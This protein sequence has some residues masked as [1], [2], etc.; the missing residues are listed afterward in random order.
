MS[1][2]KM[3][4]EE[5]S[6][7]GGINTK[8]SVYVTGEREVLDLVNFD[9]STPGAWTKRLGMTNAISGNTVTFG[10]SNRANFGF[11]V[12]NLPVANYVAFGTPAT[13]TYINWVVGCSGVYTIDIN[14]GSFR[15]F[16][17]ADGST[18]PLVSTD[19][20]GN[21]TQVTADAKTMAYFSAGG[22]NYKNS[23]TVGTSY[24]GLPEYPS[25]LSVGSTGIGTSWA[26][27]TYYFKSSYVD[28]Y[29]YIGKSQTSTLALTIGSSGA[30]A[31]YVS[32][33]TFTRMA[34]QSNAEAI[35]L[36][37]I[38]PNFGAAGVYNFLQS[39]L[40]IAGVVA[41]TTAI[42]FNVPNQEPIY[43]ATLANDTFSG[44]NPT[45]VADNVSY[46]A[47]RLF[48]GSSNWKNYLIYSE[49]IETQADAEKILPDSF[50]LLPN[51]DFP[52]VASR[53]YN[54]TLMVFNQKGVTRLTGEDPG[55]FQGVELTR[56]Y[57]LISSRA[58]VEWNEKIWFLDETEIIEYN[59]ANFSVVSDRMQ[60]IMQ[61]MNSSAAKKC[62][63]AYYYEERNEVW[64][65]I[66][67]DSSNENNIVIVYDTLAQ[68]F[69]TLKSA[70][71]FNLLQ[72][73]SSPV[74]L[75]ATPASI[76]L[77]VSPSYTQRNSRLFVSSPGGSLTYFGS[78]FATDAGQVISLGVKTRFHAEQGHSV[79][80][81]WRRLYLDTGPW[82]SVTL[83]FRTNFYANF[84]TNTI[85]LTRTIFASGSQYSGQQQT[86]I[87]FGIPAKSLA[88][89]I[90]IGTTN[91]VKVYGYTIERRFLRNV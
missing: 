28:S 82:N 14:D 89:D 58:I 42:L 77:R 27:G 33:F 4:K 12:V 2:Q 87:D 61:R 41:A 83:G 55:N 52:F 80:N 59:G 23:Y 29:S 84:S 46:Y 75:P 40:P 71:N 37:Y 39:E 64:F 10:A 34:I 85:S 62:A 31:V 15:Y 13:L 67:L 88:M 16:Q 73:F 54:Q 30:Y 17:E 72:A 65:A 90:S 11:Q 36:F 38:D 68:G 49:I 53:A 86:R 91:P 48:W 56:Q 60:A 1:Y 26:P 24:Y 70:F 45:S 35:Y 21:A 43:E 25:I 6:N 22:L 32:G 8:A 74:A 51:Q 81:E 44:M 3:K 50:I 69:T 7:I 76:S 5:Y 47:K 78:S 19:G 63:A 79:T 18:H 9:F 20:R 57:G 66:P